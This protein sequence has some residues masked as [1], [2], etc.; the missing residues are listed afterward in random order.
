MLNSEKVRGFNQLFLL[1]FIVMVLKL[2]YMS[3][4]PFFFPMLLRYYTI[5]EYT[6][7]RNIIDVIGI[8]LSA[9][10]IVAGYWFGKRADMANHYRDYIRGMVY[11]WVLVEILVAAGWFLTDDLLKSFFEV[12]TMNGLGGYSYL[13]PLFSGITLGWLVE[14]KFTVQP[15]WSNDILRYVL[16]YQVAVMVQ[17][18]IRVYLSKTMLFTSHQLST[19]GFYTMILSFALLPVSLWFLWQMYETGKRV[20]LRAEYGCILFTLW[21]PRVAVRIIRLLAEML[22]IGQMSVAELLYLGFEDILGVSVGVFGNA[23]AILCFGYIH[24]KYMNVELLNR[25]GKQEE[26]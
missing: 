16:V 19:F 24:S 11:S 18:L 22:V 14:E 1:S 3:A 12:A 20:E 5:V 17:S 4:N 23:F 25:L 7:I 13:V 10:I 26:D 21:G 6:V 9:I 2:A 15:V 8:I